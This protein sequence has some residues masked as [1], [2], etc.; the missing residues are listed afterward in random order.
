[1]PPAALIS[2]TKFVTTSFDLQFRSALGRLFALHL[3][4]PHK[5]AKFCTGVAVLF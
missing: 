5:D 1:M 3:A 4:G 2:V